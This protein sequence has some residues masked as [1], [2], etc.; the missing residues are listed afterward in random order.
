MFHP[1]IRKQILEMF[2]TTIVRNE[3]RIVNGL[4]SLHVLCHSRRY[5]THCSC[6]TVNGEMQAK[7][8]SR[9]SL[10]QYIENYCV[11]FRLVPHSWQKRL[12]VSTGVEQLG[13]NRCGSGSLVPQS[14]QNLPGLPGRRQVGQ[15]TVSGK[16]GVLKPAIAAGVMAA[17]CCA[18]G[19]CCCWRGA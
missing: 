2:I 14:W 19:S 10:Y 7:P 4:S 9:L 11:A 8:T 13:Q 17:G 5:A 6:C 16:P 18:G 12:L 15:F 3:K 1:V